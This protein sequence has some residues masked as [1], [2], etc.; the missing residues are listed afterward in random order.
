M[1][2]AGAAG[3]AWVVLVNEPHVLRGENACLLVCLLAVQGSVHWLMAPTRAGSCDQGPLGVVSLLQ[4]LSLE[5]AAAEQLYQR[6]QAKG[7]EQHSN[8]QGA[9]DVEDQTHL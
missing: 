5:V 7:Q 8:S 1:T 3:G 2:A 9:K 6:I 4:V